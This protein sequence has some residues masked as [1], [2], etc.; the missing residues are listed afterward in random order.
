MKTK[1]LFLFLLFQLHHCIGQEVEKE[2]P[3]FVMACVEAF[4]YGDPY[5]WEDFPSYYKILYS[6]DKDNL[7]TI[8]TLN[9]E[10]NQITIMNNILQSEDKKI[11]YFEESEKLRQDKR[12]Y[13]TFFDYSGRFILRRFGIDWDSTFTENIG[14]PEILSIDSVFIVV[15]EGSM[16]NGNFG[17]DRF[18]KRYKLLNNNFLN[19]IIDGKSGMDRSPDP[20]FI[21][22][23]SSKFKNRLVLGNDTTIITPYIMP[24]SLFNRNL[25]YSCKLNN[26]NYLALRIVDNSKSVKNFNCKMVIFNKINKLWHSVNLP[27]SVPRIKNWGNWFYGSSMLP[28]PDSPKIISGVTQQQKYAD[29]YDP[30]YGDAA[31]LILFTGQLYLYNFSTEKII[32][33]NT[34]DPDSEIITIHEGTIYYRV[35]D[36]IRTVELDTIKNEINWP[37]QKLLIKDK[38]RVPNIHWMFFAHKQDKVEEVWVN[39]PKGIKE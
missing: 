21:L 25:E 31:D 24:D 20:Y 38:K 15:N 37:S 26:H 9:S 39:R 13:F 5:K 27:T 22:Y 6:L 1:Y 2:V 30:Q 33:W 10:N 19:P 3:Y 8:D 29:R 17:R 36:E 11:F 35:F 18:F 12:K 7:K 28:Q 4:I 34:G 14:R 32:K 23:P 16:E